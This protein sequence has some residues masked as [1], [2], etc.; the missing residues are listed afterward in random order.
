MATVEAPPRRM[1][2]NN[3]PRGREKRAMRMI[4]ELVC[5]N[6]TNGLF[7]AEQYFSEIA[8]RDVWEWDYRDSDGELHAGVTLT[9]E[10]AVEA[11]RKHGYES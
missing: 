10:K 1:A 3:R 4:D 9:R 11:A 7:R 6:K 8:Q 5:G 2:A